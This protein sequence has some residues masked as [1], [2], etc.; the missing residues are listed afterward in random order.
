MF[1]HLFNSV[2]YF[3]LPSDTFR[4]HVERHVTRRKLSLKLTGFCRQTSQAAFAAS[5]FSSWFIFQLQIQLQLVFIPFFILNFL[6][7]CWELFWGLCPFMNNIIFYWKKLK[8][9]GQ[10]EDRR[11]KW[12]KL[13]GC[14]TCW[15]ALAELQCRGQHS[16]EFLPTFLSEHTQHVFCYW[17]AF[18]PSVHIESVNW[19]P[20]N[21]IWPLCWLNP[22]QQIKTC[23]NKI[24]EQEIVA[25]GPRLPIFENFTNTTR[26]SEH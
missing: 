25:V 19:G 13:C 8:V 6:N 20:M 11:W 1:Y 12:N 23:V 24:L 4:K 10:V 7:Y 21:N 22:D 5:S 3:Y 18:L 2:Q 26:T 17:L 16:N 14:V 9:S 15:P